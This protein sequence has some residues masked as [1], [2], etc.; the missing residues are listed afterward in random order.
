MPNELNVQVDES[1]EQEVL[2]WLE[3]GLTTALNDRTGQEEKWQKHIKQYEEILPSKKTF[4]WEGCSNMSVPVTPTAVETVH[5]RE[6]NTI[7]AVRPYIQVRP[8]KDGSSPEDCQMVELFL[9]H[10]FDSVIKLYDK[11][12]QWFLEK[13]KMGT[14][15]AK[16]FW[17]YNKKKVLKKTN[18][19]QRALGAPEHIRVMVEESK[20]SMDVIAIEDIIFPVNSKETE[21]ADF[22]AHRI[23]MPFHKFKSKEAL[24][25]Y[26]NVDKIENYSLASTASQTGQDIQKT[27][28]EAE[29]LKRTDQSQ[30]D[31]REAYEIHFEYDIDGD[32]LPEYTVLTMHLES[33]TKLRWVYFPY[34]HGR[35]PVIALNYMPRVNRIYG[36]GICEML[37]HIQDSINTVFN[38]TIDNST[39]ANAKCFKGRKSARKDVGKIFPGKT[40]WLDDPTDLEEFSLGD[41][42][43]SNFAIHNLL[44]TYGERRTK[45]NDYT[46]GRES[47]LMKSRA[48]ATGTLA[49]LQESGRHFDM[50]INNTRQAIIELAYQVIELYLQYDPYKIFKVTNREGALLNVRLP[51]GI[52]SFREEYELY[53]TA[54]SLAVNKEI[55]K[56][57]N[58]ILMQQLGTIFG[59]MIQLLQ[60]IYTNPMPDDVKNF[61]LGTV[62]AY[63][64]LAEDLVRSFEKVDVKSYLPELPELVKTAFG[65]IGTIDAM[66][67]RMTGGLNGQGGIATGMEGIQQES[68]MGAYASEDGGVQNEGT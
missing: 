65:G 62:K 8:K 53:C 24:G 52:Q 49:L 13:D 36:L 1:K 33:K 28:E 34:T 40:F 16:V 42:H 3:R 38:Q 20:V 2:I 59:Q 22:L 41:V 7:F 30:L 67:E 43:Q 56:Q 19:I 4:P 68:S 39:I 46:L 31:E 51:S 54:T 63:Y 25:I 6:V 55:E 29:N 5:A 66:I 10:I 11:G 15:F 48:T 18:K 14:G 44:Q 27:K 17:N 57:A 50:I 61:M 47:S 60:I 26:E 45:V 35:R 9:D 21:T 58:L 23:R 12:S 64:R 32:G 37:E